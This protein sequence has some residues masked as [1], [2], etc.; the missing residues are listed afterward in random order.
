[1]F[2]KPQAEHAWLDQFLGTWTFVTDSQMPEGKIQTC[3][4]AT[5]RSLGGLWLIFESSWTSSEGETH[6]TLIT[7]GYDSA[8]SKYVGTFVGSMMADF[9]HYVGELE[10]GKRLPL[11][12]EGPKF[13][14]SGR[15]AYRDTFI[16]IDQDTWLFTGELQGDDGNWVEFMSSKHT[17]KH[18]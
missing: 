2:G 16:A 9:W 17:R 7:L 14:G 13:D 10:D 12:S 1:M 8:K 4:T 18:D 11:L 15:C 5:C 6:T 3:G